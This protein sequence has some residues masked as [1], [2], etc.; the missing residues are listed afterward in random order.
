MEIN[1]T[2]PFLRISIK[3]RCH[4]GSGFC[5]LF[6]IHVLHFGILSKIG[7]NIADE[8]DTQ[9]KEVH[10]SNGIHCYIT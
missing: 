8:G 10:K 5:R 3:N 9:E 1:K 6:V 7:Q 2:K 4:V